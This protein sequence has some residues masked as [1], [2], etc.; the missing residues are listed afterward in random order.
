MQGP[1][2]WL[3]KMIRCIVVISETIIS[4]YDQTY[5]W[6]FFVAVA[7]NCLKVSTLSNEI[8]VCCIQ[9]Y[10]ASMHYKLTE[11][12]TTEPLEKTV[13][14]EHY[15][16]LFWEVPSGS[17]VV[18]SHGALLVGTL[19]PES[20]PKCRS[21][22]VNRYTKCAKRSLVIKECNYCLKKYK[23]WYAKRGTE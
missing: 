8:Y 19:S 17:S 18:A 23:F 10:V 9:W 4:K 14:V 6:L 15:M 2:S 16:L 7:F 12:K 1:I 13:Q 21:H 5:S 22:P 20:L 11:L 3:I